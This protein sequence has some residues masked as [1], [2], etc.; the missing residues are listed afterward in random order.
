MDGIPR[1]PQSP[2][3][4]LGVHPAWRH[5]LPAHIAGQHSRGPDVAL[6]LTAQAPRGGP[7]R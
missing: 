3:G 7:R 1:L 4:G 6:V 2:C 5:V